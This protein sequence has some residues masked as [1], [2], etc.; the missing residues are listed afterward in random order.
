MAVTKI[1]CV[2][3][4]LFVFLPAGFSQNVRK[5]E[6]VITTYY[7][8]PYGD[9]RLLRLYP[10]RPSGDSFACD[11][12]HEG[13]MYYDQDKKQVMSCRL[14]APGKYSWQI[15]GLWTQVGSLIYPEDLTWNVAIGTTTPDPRA[16]LTVAGSVF[17]DGFKSTSYLRIY[18]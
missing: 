16:K 17:A 6:L 7:P 13:T 18:K 15:I 11:E 5:E 3:L 2:L 14:I 1:L 12:L 9:Y 10:A 4:V 8:V